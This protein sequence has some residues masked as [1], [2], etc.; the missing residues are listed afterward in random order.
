[1]QPG[2]VD[3][4]DE[5]GFAGHDFAQDGAADMHDIG[6]VPDD[7]GDAHEG[8]FFGVEEQLD[9]VGLHLVAAEAEE[10]GAGELFLQALDDKGAV[11]ITGGFAGGDED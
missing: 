8:E 11:E 4:D 3:Q 7:F 2:V 10:G 9:A 1:M 6:E 5:F